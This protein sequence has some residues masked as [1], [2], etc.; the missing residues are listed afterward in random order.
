MSTVHC[1]SKLHVW[2]TGS[3][4]QN[5]IITTTKPLLLLPFFFWKPA[6]KLGI[7]FWLSIT[8]HYIT[9]ILEWPKHKTTTTTIR[10]VQNYKPKTVNFV[11]RRVILHF[12]MTA[13]QIW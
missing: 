5:S 4:L 9:V 13:A 6:T 12:E 3:D 11:F 10:S 2:W 7:V 1:R 8:L